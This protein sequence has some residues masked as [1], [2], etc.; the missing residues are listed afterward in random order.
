MN[1]KTILTLVGA[2]LLSG[3]VNEYG[4]FRPPDPLGRAVFNLFDP[5]PAQGGPPPQ[6]GG[7]SEYV[8][9]EDM[10]PTQY[11]QR[12]NAPGPGLVW[13]AGYWSWNGTR[14]NWVRGRWIEAPRIGSQWVAPQYYVTNGQRYWRPG[15]W[16]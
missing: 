6:N 2:T 14:W 5:P 15:Y 11:E 13:V 16:R 7:G 4:H 3:C 9:N 10:P 1:K 8:V 12:P